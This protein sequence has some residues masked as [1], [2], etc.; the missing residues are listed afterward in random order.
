MKVLLTAAAWLVLQVG[1]A[2]AQESFNWRYYSVIPNTHDFATHV[3]ESFERIEERSEGRLK[4]RFVSY[5][6][7]P[8]KATDAL[9]VLKQGQ[10]EMTEWLPSYSAGTYPVLA[11]P[12]LPF[13]LPKMTL[14]EDAQE[15]ID[16]AWAAPRMASELERVVKE[17]GGEMLAH[18]YYEPMNFWFTTPVTSKAE[19]E[20]KRVRVFS[21]ELGELVTAVGGSSVSLAQP[22]VYSALQRNSLDGVITGVGNLGG[23][24]QWKEVL[25]SGFI[26][27]PMFVS[28]SVLVNADALAEL[29]D[30]L[31]AIL[32]EEMKQLDQT[33]TA[34]MPESDRTKKEELRAGSDFVLTDASPEDY[35]ALREIA[36]TRVWPAWKGRVGEEVGKVLEEILGQLEANQ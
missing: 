16:A 2:N 33:Q 8:Y 25:K 28:T 32:I 24:G 5:G 23:G 10:V 21:P 31:K 7:T 1:L 18:Y 15:A 13:L 14:P 26:A 11:T 20:S 12:E 30:D 6:E 27:N 4:I 9:N 35:A 34:F 36:S 22:E 3:L 19:F 17:N 29:P